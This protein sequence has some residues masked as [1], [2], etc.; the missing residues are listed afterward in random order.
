MST[1]SIPQNFDFRK[2]LLDEIVPKVKLL[3]GS[4]Q[5]VI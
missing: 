2:S 3:I 5:T 1:L 4:K